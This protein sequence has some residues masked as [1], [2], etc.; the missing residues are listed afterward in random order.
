MRMGIIQYID[1]GNIIIKAERVSRHSENYHKSSLDECTTGA[2][3]IIILQ[4]RCINNYIAIEVQMQFT[5]SV[6]QNRS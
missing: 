6:T 3:K 4:A 1:A 2:V 5:K